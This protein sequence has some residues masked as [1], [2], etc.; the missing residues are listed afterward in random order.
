[1]PK[2]LERSGDLGGTSGAE[3][4]RGHHRGHDRVLVVTDEQTTFTHHGGA[5][6]AVPASA[7]VHAWNPAGYR[8]GHAPSGSG[9]RHTFGELPDVAFRMVPLLEAG[10]DADRPPVR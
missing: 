9:N 10:R 4:V 8:V 3:A 6:T 2:I 5:T 1:M 7:P